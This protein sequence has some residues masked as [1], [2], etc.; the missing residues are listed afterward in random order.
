MSEKK[1]A[2]I[3][4]P[5]SV[6]CGQGNKGARRDGTY[7]NA[8]SAFRAV[9]EVWDV[10]CN[11]P[12]VTPSDD[13]EV[14]N[15]LLSMIITGKIS[16]KYGKRLELICKRIAATAFKAIIDNNKNLGDKGKK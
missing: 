14:D 5:Q 4:L 7:T 12:K 13:Y 16:G 15:N 9:A 8:V 3:V 2:L 1:A 11:M 10:T 6:Y